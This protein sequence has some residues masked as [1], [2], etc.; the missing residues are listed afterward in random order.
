MGLQEPLQPN[1]A[2]KYACSCGKE[3]KT[4]RTLH[5]HKRRSASHECRSD[6]PHPT[7]SVGAHVHSYWPQDPEPRTATYPGKV[8]AMNKDGSY[9]IKFDDGKELL[10]VLAKFIVDEAGPASASSSSSSSSSSMDIAATASSASSASSGPSSSGGRAG[11]KRVRHHAGNRFSVD[12]AVIAEWPPDYERADDEPKLLWQ[13]TIAATN[14]DGTYA[15]D[16]EN[17]TKQSN[18]LLSMI[19]GTAEY[20]EAH[21]DKAEAESNS[22]E[23][24]SSSKRHKRSGSGRATVQ[25]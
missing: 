11:S 12:D 3:F 19:V 4:V 2:G 1:A 7:R 23:A 24:E 17:G 18:V 6:L 15:I 21:A 22:A 14:A 5:I 20:D 9:H 8:A 16:Y 13:G 25:L 10:H